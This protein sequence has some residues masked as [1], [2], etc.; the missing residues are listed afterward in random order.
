METKKY[1]LAKDGRR[2]YDD[3]YV[4]RGM[5]QGNL[6]VVAARKSVGK[7]S[8]LVEKDIQRTNK[9]KRDI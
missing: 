5:K 2:L 6:I 3:N 4:S 9:S 1:R 8:L 7:S